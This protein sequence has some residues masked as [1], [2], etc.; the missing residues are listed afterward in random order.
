MEAVAVFTPFL[1]SN[2]H[3]IEQKNKQKCKNLG[4]IINI[5]YHFKMGVWNEKR[6]NNKK[7]KG[8]IFFKEELKNNQIIID[9]D[10][11]GLKKTIFADFMSTKQE[12]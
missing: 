5:T 1:I 6:C 8:T 3:F 7:I 10:L 12:I 9:I 4:A 2:A 11:E